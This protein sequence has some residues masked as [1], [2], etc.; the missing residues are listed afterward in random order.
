MVKV[1]YWTIILMSSEY[2]LVYEIIRYYFTKPIGNFE[3][4]KKKII[5]LSQ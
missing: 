3:K 1:L 4:H 2:L 5:N